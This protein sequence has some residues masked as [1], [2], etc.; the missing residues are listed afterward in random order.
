MIQKLSALY[1]AWYKYQLQTYYVIF[2]QMF[3]QEY[4]LLFVF[5]NLQVFVQLLQNNAKKSYDWILF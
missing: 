4:N 2:S 5:N 1:I 3:L